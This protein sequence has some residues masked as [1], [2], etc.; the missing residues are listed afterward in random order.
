MESNITL[1]E[2]RPSLATAREIYAIVDRYRESFIPWLDR[3]YDINCAFDE[4]LFLVKKFFS[5]DIEYG[6]YLDWKFIWC[7]GLFNID[8]KS[9][10]AELWVWMD[11]SFSGHWYMTQAVKKLWLSCPYHRLEAKV[12][13]SNTKS[14]AVLYRC[15]F[16]WEW[17]LNHYRFSPFLGYNRSMDMYALET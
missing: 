2:L 14:K 16:S 6:I 5:K 13:V 3:V 10:R 4:F 1:R 9:S 8:E 7:V 12:D 17:T 11:P 15:W